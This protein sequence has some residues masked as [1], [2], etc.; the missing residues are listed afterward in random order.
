LARR[1]Y[2]RLLR[3]VGPNDAGR[4]QSSGEADALRAQ[5]TNR[6]SASTIYCQKWIITGAR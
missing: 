2:S 1:T 4:V 6:A 5:N 3:D